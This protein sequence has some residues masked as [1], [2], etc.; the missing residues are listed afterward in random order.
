VI[1]TTFVSSST[2]TTSTTPLVRVVHPTTTRRLRKTT[3]R[4]HR[5]QNQNHEAKTTTTT[6]VVSSPSTP[7]PVSACVASSSPSYAPS[8]HHQHKSESAPVHIV[9]SKYHETHSHYDPKPNILI[10]KSPIYVITRVPQ[11]V[12]KK[13]FTVYERSKRG[14]IKRPL[15]VGTQ[16]SL[17]HARLN[18]M[19]MTMLASTTTTT[20]AFVAPRATKTQVRIHTYMTDVS[21]RKATTVSCPRFGENAYFLRR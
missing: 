15:S 11:T 9:S 4:R 17:R 2:T 12:T 21:D 8:I 14:K 18:V 10:Y 16:T 20:T 5:H 19:M 1:P 3:T 13:F 7:P 6:T